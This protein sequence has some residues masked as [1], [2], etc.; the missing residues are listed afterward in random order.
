MGSPSLDLSRELA[1]AQ[2]AARAAGDYLLQRFGS[3]Q[4]GKVRA[5][6]DTQL[7]VDLG[8]DL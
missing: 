6:R 5:A 2:D 3:A 4:Q 7:D 8:A 1:V